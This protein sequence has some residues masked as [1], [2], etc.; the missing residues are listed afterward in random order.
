MYDDLSAHGVNA[1]QISFS[2][3]LK[4][5]TA[6]GAILACVLSMPAQAQS[7][8]QTE[9]GT[10]ASSEP[11]QLA[12]ISVEGKEDSGYKTDNSASSKFTAPLVDTPKT[13]TVIPKEIIEQ[14]NATSL[15]EVLRTTPGITLG[16]GE[17]G[18][19]SG[20]RPNIRGFSSEGNIYVDGLRDTGSQTRD[21]FNL[22]QVEIIKGPGSAYSG[23]GSTGGS[24]NLVTKKASLE[25]DFLAGNVS[26]GWPFSK[27]AA[28]DANYVLSERAAV[29]LNVLVEDSEVAGRDEVTTSSLGFA[30]SMALQLNDTTKATLSLYHLQT[31]DMP[32]YGHPYDP[33][34]GKPVDVDRDNFYGLTN[35][36]FQKTQV[37]SATLDFEHELNNSLTLR[38]VSRYS[39]SENDYIVTNPNDSAADNI[40]EGS[41]WRA[42]KSR[43]SD[44]T[45]VSNQ[46]DLSGD[47]DTFGLKNS[48]NTGIELSYE[49]SRNRNYSVDTGNRDCSV[50]GVGAAGGFNCTSLASPDPNDPWN[51]SITTSTNSTKTM[52]STR[53][54]YG[55]DTLELDPQ[56]LLNFGVRLDDYQT[57]SGTN[58]NHS[59]FVNYQLGAVY[60]PTIN[61][62][63]YV[64]YGTSSEP[65]GTTAGD[66]GDNI[67][68]SNADLDPEESRSY[69]IGTKWDLFENRMAATAALFRTEKT[70]ARVALEPGRGAAQ[71]LAGEQVI[72]GVELG[73]SGD[74]TDQWHVFGGYTF[75]DSEIVDDGPIGS[76]DGNKIPN[77]PAH[78]MS[79]WS[80]YDITSDLNMGGGT[81]YVAHRYANTANDKKVPAYWLFDAVAT[82]AVHEDVD[83][84]LNVNNVFDTTYYIKPYQTHFATVGPGRSVVLSSSFKF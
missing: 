61:S 14:R 3:R 5:G 52:V 44:T 76:S 19:P 37:D 75:M 82:Y 30:P 73:V 40:S 21:T 54:I 68:A 62:S 84:R 65:S 74:V 38:N 67:S 22:E 4:A 58:K 23:R 6:I 70:N 60:K 50:G 10:Q 56:F 49:T 32:D 25:E 47:F 17:G 15:D 12:P 2:H 63:V 34:T 71:T 36:D 9:T 16:A 48:F 46:T 28:G 45:V 81:T 78:S 24:I 57:K 59:T 39:W 83:L 64:S 42:V 13:V 31:D 43:N 11:V 1:A 66:G 41:V 7:N 72:N 51:G 53:S 80:T 35:R 20:D 29:R 8:N 27:R 69:E 79:I 18:T 26:V 55:F 33:A 77:V